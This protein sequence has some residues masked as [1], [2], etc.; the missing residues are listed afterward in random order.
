[1]WKLAESME[2]HSWQQKLHMQRPCGSRRQGSFEELTMFV[3]KRVVP[4]EVSAGQEPPHA[5]W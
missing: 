1:M 4:D 3:A 2:G 5:S